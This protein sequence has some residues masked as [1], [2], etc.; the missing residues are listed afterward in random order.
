LA[1]ADICVK[2]LEDQIQISASA[3]VQIIFNFRPS[4]LG[5]YNTDTETIKFL[6][7]SRDSIN[8]EHLK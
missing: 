4:W 7:I 8:K 5:D 6:S 3:S 1:S 2:E